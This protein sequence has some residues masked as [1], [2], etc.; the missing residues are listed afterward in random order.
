[1]WIAALFYETCEA[2]FEQ[3]CYESYLQRQ[4]IGHLTTS[5]ISYRGWPLPIAVKIVPNDVELEYLCEQFGVYPGGWVDPKVGIAAEYE[6]DLKHFI[7]SEKL[8]QNIYVTTPTC[9]AQPNRDG[10][11]RWVVAYELD[12]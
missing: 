6:R 7:F 9:I 10:V 1:M 4:V 3:C 8:G 12:V 11:L 5:E 2:D